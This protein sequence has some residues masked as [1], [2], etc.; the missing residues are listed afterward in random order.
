[1]KINEMSAAMPQCPQCKTFHPPIPPGEKCPMVKDNINGQEI[2]YSGLLN[3]L[4]NV[5]LSQIK[6]KGIK[7]IP[8]LFGFVQIEMMKLIENYKEV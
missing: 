8:K 3:N 6:L 4:R 2:D 5:I 7:N 1:M